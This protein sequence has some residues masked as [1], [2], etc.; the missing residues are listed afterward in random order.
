MTH[1]TPSD[2]DNTRK[3]T[4]LEDATELVLY[5]LKT[6]GHVIVDYRL[7]HGSAFPDFW[8]LDSKGREWLIEVK[9]LAPRYL[10]EY[11][12]KGVWLWNK[13]WVEQNIL[14]KEWSR[15]EYETR[16][17]RGKTRRERTGIKIPAHNPIPALVVSVWLFAQD[18]HQALI[19]FFGKNIVTLGNPTFYGGPWGHELYNGLR[20]LFTS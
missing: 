4:D 2:S 13:R 17:M 14:S 8:V 18:A 10:I 15:N 16:G 3:G 11:A 20:R 7:R 5:A 6:D 9:N 1:S 12:P 19:D